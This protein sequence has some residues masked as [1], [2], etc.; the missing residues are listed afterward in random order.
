MAWQDHNAECHKEGIESGSAGF[1]EGLYAKNAKTINYSLLSTLLR[2]A[3]K[4]EDI[5]LVGS[6][7]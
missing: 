5:F 4:N 1:E 6:L 2:E 3:L 7:W